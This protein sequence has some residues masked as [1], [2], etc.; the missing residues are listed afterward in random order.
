MILK[1]ARAIILLI[2]LAI[3]INF[4]AEAKQI[5]ITDTIDAEIAVIG[6]QI[7]T[8]QGSYILQA[9]KGAEYY[10]MLWSHTT[11]P[12]DGSIK[13]ADNLNAKPTDRP[14]DGTLLWQTIKSTDQTS[15][16]R[17]RVDTYDGPKG[18][19]YVVVYQ[20]EI[21]KGIWQRSENVGPE[22]WRE[23]SWHIEEPDQ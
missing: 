18:K 1:A 19:G 20:V 15:N 9:G 17:I 8:F 14:D 21:T 16:F 12:A 13:T 22:K 2:I 4:P 7:A 5:I 10:Q 6:P 11:L 3:L 23:Q